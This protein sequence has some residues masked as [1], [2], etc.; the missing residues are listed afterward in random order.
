MVLLRALKN[1]LSFNSK[2]IVELFYKERRVEKPLLYQCR[3]RTKIIFSAFLSPFLFVWWD[4]SFSVGERW[5]KIGNNKTPLKKV[6]V[7]YRNGRTPGKFNLLNAFLR[8]WIT[9]VILEVHCLIGRSCE[10]Y[11][12]NDFTPLRADF[13]GLQKTPLIRRH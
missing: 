10:L 12:N 11:A 2:R 6:E 3:M 8:I 13:S 7:S 1:I 5:G 9:Q 4:F